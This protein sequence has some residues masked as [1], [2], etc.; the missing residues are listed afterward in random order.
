M[1][2]IKL[3]KDFGSVLEEVALTEISKKKVHLIEVFLNMDQ[4]LFDTQPTL[5]IVE[6]MDAF[7]C[8]TESL[9]VFGVWTDK[10]KLDRLETMGEVTYTWN[11]NHG[12]P[13]H[14]K[15]K[16]EPEWYVEAREYPEWRMAFLPETSANVF[17][18]VKEHTDKIHHSIDKS[19]RRLSDRSRRRKRLNRRQG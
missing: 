4:T 5:D 13:Y 1:Q 6:A 15:W 2:H 16:Y 11:I 7:M 14:V 10:R 19:L 17:D 12:Q 8:M 9:L 3:F 18:V